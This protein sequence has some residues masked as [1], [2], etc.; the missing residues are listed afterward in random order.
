MLCKSKN[1]RQLCS[2]VVA[3]ASFQA[4]ISLSA[5]LLFFSLHNLLKCKNDSNCRVWIWKLL[6]LLLKRHDNHTLNDFLRRHIWLRFISI[7][8]IAFW[9]S[10]YCLFHILIASI[11]L[12]SKF[13]SC[14]DPIQFYAF[15][16]ENTILDWYNFIHTDCSKDQNQCLSVFQKLL[17]NS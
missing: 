1:S 16:F 2:P 15:Y 17:K 4:H 13:S 9:R 12:K 11:L 8:N 10:F 7:E 5:V 14:W 3:V 6:L